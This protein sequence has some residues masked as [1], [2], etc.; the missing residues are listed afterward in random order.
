M[1]ASEFC[2]QL[3]HTTTNRFNVFAINSPFK[4]YATCYHMI[5]EVATGTTVFLETGGTEYQQKYLPVSGI[6]FITCSV[7]G[8]FLFLFVDPVDEYGLLVE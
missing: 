3:N 6:L 1:T 2:E 7:I 5:K 8:G 4:V